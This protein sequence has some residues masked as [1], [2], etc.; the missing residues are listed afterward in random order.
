MTDPLTT[1]N[2]LAERRFA[3]AQAAARD[4]DFAAAAEVL[5]QTLE[6]DPRWSAAWFAL[7]DARQQSAN[8]E[9]ARKA[10]AEALRLDPADR[11]GASLR[12]AALEGRAPASLPPAYVA[13]LFD[14]YAP[15]FEG[16]LTAE[17]M[18]RGPQILRDAVNAL[19]PV[20]RFRRAL[21]L[22]CGSGLAGAAF[23]PI[24]EQLA[25]VDLSAA[26]VEEARRTGV[27]DALEVGDVAAFLRAQAPGEADL[28]LAA[29]V[30]VYLGDLAPTL[31]AAAAALAPD[32]LV[33]FTTEAE[34]GENYGLSETLR[35]R[36]S[37]R[38]LERTLAGADL[39]PLKLEPA[40][41]RREAGVDVQ[42]F[43]VVARR[44]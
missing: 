32:G 41:T 13:R 2:P 15:R 23:R 35:F 18:Y 8:F 22:G 3:Y 20:R 37:R 40:S 19:A 11:Q 44:P 21:D 7:G 5:E 38:Y 25:G 27:Y 42:G 4:R 39:G 6:L 34:A 14:D 29:D 1:Q 36:H 12:L 24:V 28:I 33:A 16:H 9:G 31:L 17:L 30:F 10:F 43:V 26:M